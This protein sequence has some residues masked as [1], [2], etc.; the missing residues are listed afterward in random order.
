MTP[1]HGATPD[2]AFPPGRIPAWL[3]PW[4]PALAF[5]L[6]LSLLSQWWTHYEF[7]TDEG[8][9]LGKSLL[10]ANGFHPYRDIWNDQPP[11]LTWILAAQYKLLGSSV[12]A[13]RLIILAFSM[14]ILRSVYVLVRQDWGRAAGWW[15]VGLLAASSSYSKLSV[16]VMIGLPAIAVALLAAELLLRRGTPGWGRVVLAGLL[17]GAAL[18]IKFFVMAAVPALILAA[19]LARG[20]RG[21]ALVAGA[22][23]ASFTA[24]A[25]IAGEPILGQII[26]PHVGD[27]LR[28]QGSIAGSATEVLDELISNAQLLVPA[29]LS[30]ALVWP[31]PT[32]RVAT[33]WFVTGAVA[34]CF[35]HPVWYHHALLF[36]VPLTLL[37][38]PAVAGL[39]R[40][41]STEAPKAIWILAAMIAAGALLQVP[42][43]DKPQ[44]RA[45]AA[46]V[47]AHGT[48]G[49]VLTDR[50]M[51]AYRAGLPV[52]PEIVVYSLKR[53]DAGNI[54]P[55]E[56]IAVAEDYDVEQVMLRR[57]PVSDEVMTYLE[58]N[59][60]RTPTP[61]AEDG[62]EEML[63]FTRTAPG[64]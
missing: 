33:L 61:P 43:G 38:G 62:T 46:L 16:S 24:I 4:L 25:L 22:A 15:C 42:T 55:A 26:A 48:D 53:R 31:T 50:P 59:F 6:L 10:V 64:G 23:A 58:R 13:A 47:A 49:W 28:A 29:L 7:D 41:A 34:L 17:T 37:C 2:P 12:F 8:I 60:T 45:A 18:Q 40:W 44:D 9:N 32:G 14:L 51:D 21:G 30:F 57:F 63:H 56:L 1:A 19:V 35:H 52:P 11:V 5:A 3:E 36:L 20:W 39:W 54:T 27:T